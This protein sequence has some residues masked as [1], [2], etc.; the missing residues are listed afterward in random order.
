MVPS[1]KSHF[2]KISSTSG[3]KCPQNGSKYG[4]VAPS[5][6]L[7]SP[8]RAFC[9]FDGQTRICFPATR[10][11]QSR[12]PEPGAC[13]RPIMPRW[14]ASILLAVFFLLV[15][16]SAAA[17]EPRE[18][19]TRCVLEAR[20]VLPSNLSL[21]GAV[22]AKCLGVLHDWSRPAEVTFP[23]ACLLLAIKWFTPGYAG[24]KAREECCASRF[25]AP[26]AMAR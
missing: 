17:E 11:G 23:L 25:G 18:S 5:T 9:G 6:G 12:V 13:T 3:D 22:G 2:W 15:A 26:S 8:H 20:V 7:G 4:S 16:L 21:T 24:A 10:P 19:E 14:P 1:I